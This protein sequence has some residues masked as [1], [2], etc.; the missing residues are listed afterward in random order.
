MT[1]NG[2]EYEDE[3][4]PICLDPI[5]NAIITPCGHILCK[6]CTETQMPAENANATCSICNRQF[7][8]SQLLNAPRK[9]ETAPSNDTPMRLQD[10]DWRSCTKIDALMQE[11]TGSLFI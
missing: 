10:A 8:T 3:E 6:R 11:L 1:K 9:S 4:C 2:I 7:E 5:D